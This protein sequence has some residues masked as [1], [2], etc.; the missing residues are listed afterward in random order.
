MFAKIILLLF[1][2]VS[3]IP[4]E[5]IFYEKD[6]SLHFS[7]SGKQTYEIEFA[8][9]KEIPERVH[10]SI[11][12]EN[13]MQQIVSFSSTHPQCK[14]KSKFQIKNPLKDTFDILLE[15]NSFDKKK[16]YLCIECPSDE[17]CNFFIK[18]DE[19]NT[20]VKIDEY[21]EVSE[22]IVE[23][24]EKLTN[25]FLKY[26]ENEDEPNLMAVTNNVNLYVIDGKSA[27]CIIIPNTSQY[28]QEYTISA[29]SGSTCSVSG[30]T[31][32]CENFVVKPKGTTWYWYGPLGTTTKR[33]GQEPDSISI[34][35]TMGKS[36]VTVKSGSTVTATYIFDVID[37]AEERADQLINDYMSTKI[38]STMIDFKKVHTCLGFPA[39]FAWVRDSYS[40]WKETINCGYG[41]AW[42]TSAITMRMLDKVGITNHL[43]YASNSI[44]VVVGHMDVAVLLDGIVYIA[45]VRS[46]SLSTPR[47][48][49]TY[50]ENV[51]WYYDYH[52]YES[53]STATVIQYDGFETN[54]EV[55]E[56]IDNFP[57]VELNKKALKFGVQ[58]SGMTVDSI[59]LPSTLK[60]IGDECFNGLKH[61]RTI[62][63]PASV[64]SIG[65]QVFNNM[66]SLESINVEPGNTKYSSIDG[67]LFN[68]AQT[69][70][71]AYPNGNTQ[72]TYTVPST[73]NTI[74][75][76][77]FANSL[78]INTIY[79]PQNLGTIEQGAFADSSLKKLY[80]YGYQPT[81]SYYCFNALSLTIYYPNN[82]GWNLNGI[83][84]YNANG[85]SWY[86]WNP[87]A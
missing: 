17:R 87:Y 55:P 6:Q 27:G 15:K 37:Y 54:V 57:V 84:L 83:G 75:Y 5:K 30:S 19:N 42:G 71:I 43:R 34:T 18:M 26:I 51:G 28:R 46:S 4:H 24:K 77:S 50:Q 12:S 22:E 65:I 72:T 13:S 32:T 16:L 85:I 73:V 3:C 86:P 60:T 25:N 29:A 40:G 49:S 69:K 63:I 44:D 8:S 1:L 66:N 58:Y 47:P 10:I 33:E 36:T 70:I 78:Y 35:Y 41:D 68:K 79:L 38:K 14:N 74:G 48:Y 82:Y 23:K 81:F 31:V 21:P 9:K 7:L 11:A 20:G 64:T 61:V 76:Y 52:Y 62:T 53:G 2:S 80:F 59:T 45:D 67:V 56:E 39:Q